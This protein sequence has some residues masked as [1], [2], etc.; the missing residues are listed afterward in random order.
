MKRLVA[1]VAGLS[2]LLVAGCSSPSDGLVTPT[3]PAPSTI[4][5]TAEHND[6]DVMFLQMAIAHHKQGLEIVKLAKDHAVRSDVKT[7]AAAIEVTQLSEIDSMTKWLGDWGKPESSGTDM[8][9]HA[10]HGGD[11]STRPEDIAEIAALPSGEFEKGFL[12]LL[13]AHQHNA[14]AI[15]KFEREGGSNPQS[16]GLADRIFESRSAQIAQMLGYLN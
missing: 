4:A 14:V 2:L 6:T 1:L 9:L 8:Q 11:H 13:I 16:K 3:G 5:E 10:D 15:A 7:L 12:N